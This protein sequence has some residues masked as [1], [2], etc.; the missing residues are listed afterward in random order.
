MF[1]G[2]MFY[3]VGKICCFFVND[4]NSD[5]KIRF[6]MEVWKIIS[7]DDLKRLGEQ[8]LFFLPSPFLKHDIFQ[9]KQHLQTFPATPQVRWKAIAVQAGAEIIVHNMQ[10]GTSA[11]LK[12]GRPWRG[13]WR[14]MRSNKRDLSSYCW[15]FRNLATQ[16]RLAVEIPLFT[17]GFIHPRWLARFLSST[18]LFV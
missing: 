9:E 16:L 14:G 15:W 2:E 17:T 18:V 1:F 12:P 4:S 7:W 13:E 6:P 5:N 10:G 11:E 3:V 8:F